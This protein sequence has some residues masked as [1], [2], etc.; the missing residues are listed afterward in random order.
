MQIPIAPQSELKSRDSMHQN[1]AD[2]SAS[3]SSRDA[4]SHCAGTCIPDLIAAGAG[5]VPHPLDAAVVVLL[6]HL[7]V[8]DQQARTGEHQQREVEAQRRPAPGFLVRHAGQRGLRRKHVLA[9]AG[10]AGDLPDDVVLLGL[11]L[12]FSLGGALGD[13]GGVEGRGDADD[14][15]GGEELGAVVGFDGDAV[16][17]FGLAELGDDGVDFEGEVDVF[18]GS[19]A[20]ELKLAVRRDERDDAVCVELAQLDALMELAVFERD[21]AGGGFGGFCAGGV[22]GWRGEAFA[23][24]EEA[25]VE[26]EFA[27]RGSGEIGAHNDLTVDVGAEDGS[28]GRHEE[29]DVLDY[30]HEGFVLAVFDV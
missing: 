1:L 17:D 26:A 10:E 29:V 22:A 28:G 11:V 15:V 19:V 20:H 24:E 12:R 4:P 14:D 6:K 25:I 2:T 16:F 7:Q 5:H 27:F 21:A 13:F 18:G 30:V 3:R 23:V 9:L 8:P